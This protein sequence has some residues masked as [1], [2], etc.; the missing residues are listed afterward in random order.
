MENQLIPKKI[1][2]YNF[3]SIG[4]KHHKL[5]KKK[6]PYIQLGVLTSQ[7]NNLSNILKG[8]KVFHQINSALNWQPEA[9]IICSPASFHLNHSLLFAEKKIPILI[10]KPIGN[11]KES[12]KDWE[13]L[14]KL[15][16]ET[17]IKVGYVL[18][19]HPSL[20]LLKKELLKNDFGKII[21]VD[22]YCGSWLPNWRENT[23]YK[24]SVSSIKNLGGGALL[25]LSHE[26]DIAHWL[27]GDLD[28]KYSYLSKY[29]S[30]DI[31]VE[32]YGIL[33]A[34][35]KNDTLITIRLNFCTNPEKREIL[36]RSEK[37]E[38][39]CNLIDGKLTKEISGE[40]IVIF[41]EKINFEKIFLTQYEQFFKN[42]YSENITLCSV[43]EAL[44][45]LN[46]INKAK[47][48]FES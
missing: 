14:L 25:E 48:D 24:K 43:E 36:I 41:N 23:N 33:I 4:R 10:E 45:I 38:I 12:K 28:L 27:F 31:D 17:I 30:L 13:I 39:Y 1:L 46:F 5:I 47:I 29:S 34:C 19:Q 21:D 42:I 6:W 16:K 9:A 15:S 40:K 44:K 37:G 32:D 11:G 18:R 22:F 26:I 7:K 35:D 2:I 3:G 20:L 8:T